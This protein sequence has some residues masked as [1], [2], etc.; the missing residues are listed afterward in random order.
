[1]FF[2]EVGLTLRYYWNN[3]IYRWIHQYQ[4]ARGFDPTTPDFAQHLGYPIYQVYDDSDRFQ[5]YCDATMPT[6]QTQPS[7]TVSKLRALQGVTIAPA[8]KRKATTSTSFST[9]TSD[10]TQSKPNP[11]PNAGTSASQSKS[12]IGIEE[13]AVRD[14]GTQKMIKTPRTVLKSAD[15][16]PPRAPSDSLKAKGNLPHVDGSGDTSK[17]VRRLE[18]VRGL[19]RRLLG[20]K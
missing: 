18:F 6:S 2:A 1:M 3:D 11:A 19:K 15:L 5:E 20:K 16:P 14:L 8:S 17:N 10:Q 4:L 7:P 9:S 13:D 12:C